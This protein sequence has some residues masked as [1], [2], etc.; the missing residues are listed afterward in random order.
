MWSVS[1]VRVGFCCLIFGTVCQHSQF[2][3][4]CALATGASLGMWETRMYM[5]LRYCL[6]LKGMR[7]MSYK[8]GGMLYSHNILCTIM[9]PGIPAVGLYPSNPWVWFLQIHQNPIPVAVGMGFHG[10]GCGRLK[11]THRLPMH[12][13]IQDRALDLPILLPEQW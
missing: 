7:R 11:I 10:Y 3:H 9:Y 5:L 8:M 1:S 4:S 12:I 6:M 13:T 2:V